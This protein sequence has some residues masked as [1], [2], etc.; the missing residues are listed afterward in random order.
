MR[1]HIESNQN[2]KILKVESKYGESNH[3][4]KDYKYNENE[5]LEYIIST[6]MVENKTETTKFIYIN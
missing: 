5:K 2:E 3:T 1:I 4:I 6:D